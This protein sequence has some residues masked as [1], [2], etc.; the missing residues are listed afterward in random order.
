MAEAAASGPLDV[1]LAD[2]GTALD[3]HR[4]AWNAL[5]T[6]CAVDTVFL[7]AEWLLACRETFAADAALIVPMAYAGSRLVAAAAFQV[8]GREISFLGQERADYCD[9]MISGEL[10]D[11]DAAAVVD[12]LLAAALGATSRQHHFML[13]H[14]PAH[15]RFATLLESA[16]TRFHPTVKGRID[17]PAMDMRVVGEKLRKK[18]LRRHEN[19]LRRSGELRLETATGAAGIEPHLDEF[20]TQHVR[21]WSGPGSVFENP[22][23]REFY[24]AMIRRFD[25]TGLLRFSRLTLDGRLIAAHLGFLHRGV[26]TWYKPT[27]DVDLARR[28]PG[29]VLLKGVLEHARDAGAREFDFTIGDEGYKMRFSTEVRQVYDL[30]VTDSRLRAGVQRLRTRLKRLVRRGAAALT[31]S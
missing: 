19:G 31:T 24:H 2:A 29:E 5:L 28:S 13:R 9:V 23:N 11:P 15:S 18:S 12:R 20:F 10:D 7:R 16:L 25:G 4:Q 6:E 27:F 3:R 17:A 14:V 30:H 8:R 21:R 22:A 1:T 26:F